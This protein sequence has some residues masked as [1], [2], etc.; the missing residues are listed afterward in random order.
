MVFWRWNKCLYFTGLNLKESDDTIRNTIEIR[1]SRKDA[2]DFERCNTSQP[3]YLDCFPTS[4]ENFMKKISGNEDESNQIQNS[5]LQRD[6]CFCGIFPEKNSR[7]EEL[8][9]KVK[10]AKLN[11]KEINRDELDREKGIKC[12]NL[13]KDEMY[14][15]LLEP[16]KYELITSSSRSSSK[17]K[18]SFLCKYD[19]C[20]K[21]FTKACNFLDHVRMHEEVRPYECLKCDVAFVQR[22][23]LVKHKKLHCE[24]SLRE[25]RFKCSLCDKS[26]TEKYSLRVSHLWIL[27]LSL[28]II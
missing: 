24:D 7:F 13:P 2:G 10:M 21:I 26:F 12:L 4:A 16:F 28:K 20:M 17:A 19:G 18:H 3:N 15:K 1:V 6:F 11:Q 22:C 9:S 8:R 27:K 5:N 14:N 25:R 23:N